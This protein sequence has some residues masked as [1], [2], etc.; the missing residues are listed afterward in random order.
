MASKGEADRKVEVASPGYAE[1]IWADGQELEST[2]DVCFVQSGA[3]AGKTDE[4]DGL[5]GVGVQHGIIWAGDEAVNAW[6]GGDVGKREVYDEP[7]FF[8]STLVWG[9]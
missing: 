3:V 1:E 6:R 4:V 2:G 5:C 8:R 7:L 9:C